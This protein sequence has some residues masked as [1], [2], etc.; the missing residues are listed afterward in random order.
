M[1]TGLRKETFDNLQMDAG[2]FVVNLKYQEFTDASQLISALKQLAAQNK[3]VDGV[4]KDPALLGA[5][6]GGGTFQATP[7]IRSV[8]ADGK[9]YEFKG[10]QRNDGWTIQ[11][12]GTL[13]EITAGTIKTTLV[14]ADV[15]TSGNIKKVTLHTDI[16]DD[17]YIEHLIWVGDT[18]QGAVLIDL[19][20]ALNTSGVSMTFTDKGEGTLPFT[21]VAHQDNVDDYDKAPVDIWLFE[22]SGAAAAN[23]E[24]A[25]TGGEPAAYDPEAES[26]STE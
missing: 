23:A 7:A 22:G 1:V 26:G 4:S 14:M 5:T 6:I 2:L 18:S 19:K 15:E 11:L 24:P 16:K 12:T 9:R 8:E 17:D 10:S 25:Q 3:V 13:K 21:F 20:N